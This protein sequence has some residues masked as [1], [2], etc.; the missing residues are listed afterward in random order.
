[1]GRMKVVGPISKRRASMLCVLSA[2]LLAAAWLPAASP[3]VAA[4]DPVPVN[5]AGPSARSRAS[6]A[7]VKKKIVFLQ[8]ACSEL[9][10]TTFDGLKAILRSSY[11]YTDADFLTYSYQ[12][13]R[14]DAISG[15]WVPNPYSPMDPINQHL[16]TSLV[17]LHDQMLVPYHNHPNNQNTTFVLVG[18][19][20]GGSVAE[21]EL[22]AH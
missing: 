6:A 9:S 3:A 19:S 13:G 17:A 4:N 20:L 2:L 10:G 14:V 5:P 12:G 16:G 1:R 18:H 8:G 21:V 22:V 7:Q 11:E 15:A